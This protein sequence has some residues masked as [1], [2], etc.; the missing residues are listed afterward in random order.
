MWNM[1]A[2][3][4]WLL[5]ARYRITDAVSGVPNAAIPAPRNSHPGMRSI[6]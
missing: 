6:D 4:R 2:A 3:A 1:L 5:A